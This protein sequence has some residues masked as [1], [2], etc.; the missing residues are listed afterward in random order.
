MGIALAT[1]SI[2]AAQPKDANGVPRPILNKLT[3]GVNITRW[4]CYREAGTNG[5]QLRNYLHPLDFASFKDLG[6]K[7][8]RLCISPDVIYRDGKPDLVNLAEVDRGI[9]RL[10]RAGLL[11]L[12][13][14]HDNG[15]L[16]L[17][18]PAKDNT[19][20]VTFWQ[21]IAEHYKG[22]K[23]NSVVFELVNEPTFQTN[24]EVWYALQERTL[25]AVRA[26]DPKR[27]IMV[28]PE[29]WSGVDALAS[30]RP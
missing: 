20:F 25:R 15:Q 21:A 24:R 2:A 6:V 1:A 19:G 9:D 8:V 14:L 10:N 17:D 30:F 23:L 27:T 12:W 22:K 3:R 16:K 26:I 29:Q 28:S 11:V 4:F 18:Q 13:D 5:V 7:F